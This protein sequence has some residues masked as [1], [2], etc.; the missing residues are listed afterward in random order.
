VTPD[1]DT[2]G[3]VTEHADESTSLP[4]AIRAWVE[5]SSGGR[6]IAA[7][8]RPGGGRREA[9]VIDVEPAGGPA[10][11]LFLRY[12]RGDPD[13]TGDPFTL[14]REAQFYLALE[15]SPVP[16]PRVVAVHGTEQAILSERVDGETWFSRLR[17]EGQRLSVARDF[18]RIL[19]SL[20]RLDPAV[21]SLPAEPAPG[22]CREAAARE[23]D[24]WERLYR[25]GDAE[26]DPMIEFGLD[27]LRRAIPDVDGPLTIVQGDTGPG[28]FL[29]QDG[30]VTA[31]LDWELAHIGDPMDDLGWLALRAVQ[32]PFTT[33]ADRLRDWSDHT[34]WAVDLDRVRYYR[35]F[36]ELR[37]V[38]L[39]HRRKESTN[40]LGEVGNGL[41]Y[42][43]L[44]RRL[45]TEAMA[46]VLGVEVAVPPDID[47]PETEHGWLYDAA[48][49]QVR[50][51][52]VP[53]STDAF[54]V[55]RAKGLA[56]ILKH[57]QQVDRLAAAVSAE[58]LSDL[59][60]LTGTVVDSLAAGRQLLAD[61][62]KDGRVKPDDA[63]RYFTRRVTRDTQLLRPAMGALADRHFD[64]LG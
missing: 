60:E 10:Q 58:E 49:L 20:H 5:E 55:Q 64:P 53:R 37:V 56:R 2:V 26:V 32:E 52:I 47:A 22:G 25:F 43:Q 54:V 19:A 63:L 36:A 24:V 18:M 61:Q 41:I 59:R 34:G 48:T 17:D 28:N 29:Y 50:D 35:V 27:W 15:D 30:K 38:I 62:L 9:W 33:L 13:V 7:D 3:S 16:V 11:A 51:I 12:D 14:H 46:D 8:R 39:G 57:L 4:P 42:G 45:F 1:P 23:I 6:I 31:V 44:H 40:L 21:V